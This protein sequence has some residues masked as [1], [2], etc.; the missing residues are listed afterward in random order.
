[1]KTVDAFCTWVNMDSMQGT[2]AI[3]AGSTRKELNEALW[4]DWGKWDDV[5]KLIGRSL[6]AIT[7]QKQINP[8]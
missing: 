6:R 2:T 7:S 3:W 5:T 4:A 8:M 1:M